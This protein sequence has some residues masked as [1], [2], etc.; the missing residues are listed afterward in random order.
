[1]ILHL[2]ES[3]PLLYRAGLTRLSSAQRKD[4]VFALL[5]TGQQG[6][7]LLQ[8]GGM[9]LL[10]AY[11]NKGRQHVLELPALPVKNV[12]LAHDPYLKK[13]CSSQSTWSTAGLKC[14]N[15]RASCLPVTSCAAF[16]ARCHAD[17]CRCRKHDRTALPQAWVRTQ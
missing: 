14:S 11:H 8:A 4:A 2:K 1:M 9:G 7:V 16:Q 17:K 6:T 5:C 10:D 13:R 3:M 12:Q 15:A